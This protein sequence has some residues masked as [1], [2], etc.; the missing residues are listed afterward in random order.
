MYEGVIFLETTQM[1]TLTTAQVVAK[2]GAGFTPAEGWECV[3]MGENAF[4]WAISLD[5]ELRDDGVR[6]FGRKH[7]LAWYG[8]WGSA[9]IDES[10]IV[11]AL[12]A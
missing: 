7:G 10:F 1:P 4:G 8:I 5:P 3:F 9:I 2:Y 11:K 6:D 12:T